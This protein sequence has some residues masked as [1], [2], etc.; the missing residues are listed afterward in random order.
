MT[1]QAIQEIREEL[2]VSHSQIFSYIHCSLK[3]K[4]QYVQQRP[5]ERIS[6]A[7]PFGKAI[8]S[9]LEI[10]YRELKKNGRPPALDKLL[11]LLEEGLILQIDNSTVPIIYK[12][13]APDKESLIEMGIGLIKAFYQN[14]DL[15][16]MEIVDVE[17][18][19]SARLFDENGQPMDFKL[20]GVIDLLLRD[21]TNNFIIVDHKTSKN[22]KSQADIDSDM[23]QTI[24]SYLLAAN[25]Y[26]FPRAEILCRFDVLRKLKKPTM[27]F[28]YTTRTAEDRKRLARIIAAVLAGIERRVFIPCKS[29]LCADCQ[30]KTACKSW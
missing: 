12:K 14:V 7:L 21:K 26:T 15:N 20:F 22:K 25:G 11:T 30:Y 2:Y 19:L 9:I 29:W 13:E 5:V 18:P 8:H 28:C 27:E 16:G 17:L 4:F 3:Y 24:Y 23:Q 10:Y 1:Q 6:S